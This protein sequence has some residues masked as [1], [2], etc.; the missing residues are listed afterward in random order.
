MPRPREK[1]PRTPELGALGLAVEKLR[2]ERGVTQEGVGEKTF[3]DHHLT[4]PIERGHGNPTFMTLVKVA[5]ALDS[6]LTEVVALT[7]RYLEEGKVERV[8][9]S[10]G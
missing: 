7:D 4:G 10:A 5:A 1:P 8:G 9:K 3:G 2:K 6:S